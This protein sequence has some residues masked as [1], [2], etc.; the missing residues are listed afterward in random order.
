MPVNL[1]ASYHNAVC[2]ALNMEDQLLTTSWNSII[3]KFKAYFSVHVTSRLAEFWATLY[4]VFF[5]VPVDKD[6]HT[7][8]N[9]AVYTSCSPHTKMLNT[10][11]RLYY[12]HQK[13][14]LH[15]PRICM[16]LC[17]CWQK[18]WGHGEKL[19]MFRQNL[20]HSLLI[21]VHCLCDTEDYTNMATVRKRCRGNCEQD[22]C[23][24]CGQPVM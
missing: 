10:H 20:V 11:Y 1:S 4:F 13:Y 12:V 6:Y 2:C 21:S 14:S 18:N 24:V 9:Q 16:K 23:L 19:N 3:K 15:K 8:I 22:C 7:P 5:S 17:L